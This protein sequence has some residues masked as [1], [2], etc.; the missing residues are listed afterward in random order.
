MARYRFALCYENNACQPGYVSEKI[1]DCICAR[2]VPIYYGSDGIEERVPADCFVNARQFR[3]LTDMK[4][5]I[6]AMPESGHRR[7]LDAMDEFCKSE[8][9][10]KFTKRHL[11]RCIAQAIGLKPRQ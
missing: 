4:A 1:A 10:K 5:F 7:Y 3:T 8:L 2:C 11:A 9:A 6:L